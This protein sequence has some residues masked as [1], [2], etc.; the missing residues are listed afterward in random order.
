MNLKVKYILT[1]VLILTLTT[2]S[3][4]K[5]ESVS[6]LF[7]GTGYLSPGTIKGPSSKGTVEFWAFKSDW[8]NQQNETM[9]S[10]H[11]N[12]GWEFSVSSGSIILSIYLDGVQKQFSFPVTGLSSGWHHI[13]FTFDGNYVRFYMDGYQRGYIFD[14]KSAITQPT[15]GTWFAIGA[16]S[17]VNN[18]GGS[19]FTGKITQV[20]IWDRCASVAE[21]RDWMH[22]EIDTNNYPI[23]KDNLLL[24]YPFDSLN[25]GIDYSSVLNSN[26]D[27][28]ILYLVNSGDSAN[29]SPVA[30]IDTFCTNVRALWN[31]FV[32]GTYSEPSGG[33]NM[34]VMD[35]NDYEVNE[36][37][38]FGHNG[39]IGVLNEGTNDGVY[40]QSKRIWFIDADH[41]DERPSLRFQIFDAGAG[42]LYYDCLPY[43]N[44]KLL[45]KSSLND[46]F[47]VIDDCD[48]IDGNLIFF[49]DIDVKDGF[50]CI[51]RDN[52]VPTVYSAMEITNITSTSANF[53]GEVG[54]DGG[55]V[56][57][58]Y[59]V[60]WNTSGDPTINDSITMDGSG[61][62]TFTSLAANLEP[63]VTY[64]IRAYAKNDEG[65]GYGET[66][67]FMTNKMYQT[68]TFPD[69][70][71]KV[72]G[73]PAFDPGAFASS[74]LPITYTSSKPEIASI[75]DGK[76]QIHNVGST[77]IWA[78]QP[79]N[80]NYSASTYKKITLTVLP[81]QLNVTAQSFTISYG[82]TIPDL[83]Y[84][85]SGFMYDDDS[86]D[87]STLPILICNVSDTSKVG[88][89]AI[90]VSGGSAVNYSFTYESALL[91]INKA[92]PTV[93]KWPE[94]SPILMGEPLEM[95]VLSGGECNLG[96]CFYYS[97][98]LYIP[99]ENGELVD[100]IFQP[101]DTLNYYS[102]SEKV[103]VILDVITSKQLNSIGVELS[104]YPNP[105]REFI[106]IRGISEPSLYSIF[107]VKG[108][109]IMSGFYD[110]RSIFVSEIESGLYLIKIGDKII[111]FIKQ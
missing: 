28:P 48:N 23:Y 105:A 16:E 22:V 77:S 6:T 24:Y 70:P 20:K 40:I 1:F 59:G 56:V 69:I 76:I 41:N 83:T 80:T 50:Y 19:Y 2:A 60:C 81:A 99:F 72:Y 107:S 29:T 98:S 67:A 108:E 65:V 111:K 109:T 33:M 87:L 52:D 11:E 89:Y 27:Y 79:G 88:E 25:I 86:S 78:Y 55:S 93:N 3:S 43:Y 58:V 38:V 26:T 101:A 97:D 44:Y 51:G 39:E 7:N 64:Y 35:F 106:I 15:N 30:I 85:I 57:S 49:K 104:L 36:S 74:G 54:C 34:G 95:A 46:T 66:M 42:S 68:V 14:F 12:G 5:G 73:E 92:L 90:N 63:G 84:N 13:A 18:A 37:D 110:G 10:F 53:G 8:E 94:P 61:T 47:M 4:V 62:G 96:G 75:K 91:K 45:I 17:M 82:E 102:L 9:I 71:A 21:L 31:A 32:Q 103:A 100:V